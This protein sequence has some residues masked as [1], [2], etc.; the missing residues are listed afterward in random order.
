MVPDNNVDTTSRQSVWS[1]VSGGTTTF[2]VKAV[3]TAGTWGATATFSLR[4]DTNAPVTTCDTDAS[5]HTNSFV[6]RLSATDDQSGV[7]KTQYRVNNGSVQIGTNVQISTEGSNTLAFWSSDSAGNIEAT[8]QVAGIK[9]DLGG[10]VFANWMLSP[11]N[12]TSASTGSARISVEVNDAVSGIGTNIPMIDYYMT[13][14]AYG[15]WKAMGKAGNAWTFDVATNWISQGNKSL[16]WKV[17]ARDVAGHVVASPEQSEY[18]DRTAD[19]SASK[20]VNQSKPNV[21]E[22]ITYTLRLTNSGPDAATGIEVT[23][24]LPSGLTY[25]SHAGGAYNS[26]AGLWT[27]GTLASGSSTTMTIQATVNTGTAG[28][29]VINTAR[30]SAVQQADTNAGNNVATASL[31][32][33]GAD[34]GVS[35]VVNNSTPNQGD[36]VAFTVTARNFGPDSANNV[37]VTDLIPTGL[38][39]KGTNAS[40]G[41]YS[42]ATGLWQV[43]ILTNGGSATLQLSAQVNDGTAGSTI[44]NWATKTFSTEADGNTAND[45]AMASVRVLMADI[46]V[47][48]TVSGTEPSEGSMIAYTLVATNS[49]PDGAT[50][51]QVLDMLPSGLTYSSHSGGTYVSSSGIWTIGALASSGSTSLVIQARVN[52]GTGGSSITNTAQV[53]TC[54]QTDSNP[55]NNTGKVSI[56]VQAADLAITKVVN[57]SQPNVGDSIIYTVAVT[58]KGPNG[59]T[60]VTVNDMLPAGIIYGGAVPSQGSYN[61]RIWNVGSLAIHGS[62]NLQILATIAA[63]TAGMTITN[64][65]F[66]LANQSDPTMAD[67]TN[68]VVLRVQ[69]ADL[70]IFKSVNQSKPNVGETITYT[71]RLTNSGPDAA[72]GIEVTDRLPSGLTYSSHAGGAYN[73][74]AGLWTVGTLASG[75]STT[76]T[77]QAT[78]NTGT[79]GSTV[80]NTARVSAVQQADTNA[81]NNV[82]TASLQVRGA[83]V[84]VS[85]VVNNSTPNQGDM[86]A[87]TVTARNF[88]PD[89]ANNVQVTDLIPTGLTIK[90]TNA[91]QGSY[92]GATG[93]WQVGILTNGGSATLQLSAQ[94]NDGTAGST[95]T[96]WATK[97]FSTEADGNTA[98]D[99]AGVTITVVSADLA[100]SKTATPIT[101]LPGSNVMYTISVTNIGPY[102][103]HN[104]VVTDTLP[105]QADLIEV[106][107]SVGDWSTN[108]SSVVFHLGSLSPQTHATMTV[109]L[110]ASQETV[111]TNMASVTATEPDTIPANN[112]ASVE[113]IASSNL[114]VM[115]TGQAFLVDTN[116]VISYQANPAVDM[117]AEGNFV[118]VWETLRGYDPAD[119]QVVGQR[120]DASG[121]AQGDQFVAASKTLPHITPQ[122]HWNP[123]QRWYPYYPDVSLDRNGNS[124]IV[125]FS[126]DLG[127][128]FRR[129]S[130]TGLPLGPEVGTGFST[131]ALYPYGFPG[132]QVVLGSL[133]RFFISMSRYSHLG[134]SGLLNLYDFNNATSGPVKTTAYNNSAAPSLIGVDAANSFCVMNDGNWQIVDSNGNFIGSPMP[135]GT[136]GTPVGLAMATNGDFVVALQYW[137]HSEWSIYAQRYSQMAEPKGAAILVHQYPLPLAAY[138]EEIVVDCADD[139][140]F[141]VV[142]SEW[143]SENG[144]GYA[145]LCMRRFDASGNPME[146]TQKVTGGNYAFAPRIAMN[147]TGDCVVVWQNYKTPRG[148]AWEQ[149]DIFAKRYGRLSSGS[150][151]LGIQAGSSTLYPNAGDAV[152]FEVVISN[153]SAATAAAVVVKCALS[154]NI[155]V[156]SWDPTDGFDPATETWSIGSLSPGSSA[157]LS[158]NGIVNIGA[159]GLSLSNAWTIQAGTVNDDQLNNN[160]CFVVQTVRTGTPKML[161]VS[162]GQNVTISPSGGVAVAEG[163]T[164]T[165][166]ITAAPD[167]HI[168]QMLING[169]RMRMRAD[170]M[171]TNIAFDNIRSDATLYVSARRHH[172]PSS[173]LSLYALASD[174]YIGWED[175]DNDGMANWQEYYA[176]TDPLD[177]L[178]Y[179]MITDMSQAVGRTLVEWSTSRFRPDFPFVVQS[180][181]GANLA[182]WTTD[183]REVRSTAPAALQWTEDVQPQSQRAG[184]YRLMVD[185]DWGG[186]CPTFIQ[187]SRDSPERPTPLRMDATSSNLVA[188]IM[189]PVENALLRSDIPIYGVAGG[190]NF[191]DYRV[192]YGEGY[193]PEQWHLIEASSNSQNMSPDFG[194]ISWMQGDLDLRGNLATWNTGL[195]NWEHLPWHPADDPTDF[196]GV[197][198]IRLVSQGRTGDLLEDRVTCEVGRA[199]A[200]CLPGIA[201]SP[202]KTVVMRFPEQALSDKFR[203]YTIF[204]FTMLG[205]AVPL[206]Q[207]DM[208]LLTDAYRIREPGEMFIKDVSLEFSWKDDGSTPASNIGIC[209]YDSTSGK[210]I[211]MQTRWDDSCK[212][213]STTIQELPSPEAIYALASDKSTARS[214]QIGQPAPTDPLKPV[215]RGVLLENDFE[216]GLG[217][218]RARDRNVGAQISIV[219]RDSGG[220]CLEAVNPVEKGNYSFTVLNSP[221]DVSEYPHL[222]FE[223]KID[224]EAKVDLFLRV[225]GRWYR[226]RLTGDNIDFYGKDVNIADLGKVTECTADDEWHSCGIDLRA[227]LRK[228]T[229]HSIVEEMIFANWS[230]AGYM[231]LDFGQNV[232]GARIQLDN[233]RIKSS[234]T[235]DS[236]G[237][238]VLWIDR[239]S[240]AASRNELGNLVGS[241]GPENNECRATRMPL[242]G[243]DGNCLVLDIDVSPPGSF[244][245]Y[246]TELG[247]RNLTEYGSICFRVCST[248]ELM[249]EIAL[250][251]V[252]GR[253]VIVPSL[254]CVKRSGPSGWTDVQILL[255]PLGSAIDLVHVAV[256]SFGFS[257]ASAADV[258]RV[259]LDDIRFEPSPI[260]S[261]KPIPVADYEGRDMQWNLLGGRNFTFENGAG[262]IHASQVRRR[263]NG[264]IGG[265]C[266]LLAYGG[267]IGLDLGQDGFS[268][269][270]WEA[271]LGGIDLSSHRYLEMSI[272]GLQGG[273]QPNVYLTDG[274]MKRGVDLEKYGQVGTEWSVIRIPIRDFADRGID[275]THVESLEFVFEWD[276]MSGAICLDDVSFQ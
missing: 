129:Y 93:L 26:G 110:M 49:G 16:F 20:T 90:G 4:V 242:D 58:N 112:S 214:E 119:Y 233:M 120:F 125:W 47:A 66:V 268:F 7:A 231:A 152:S 61:G 253:Q 95:I 247:D 246:W 151:N 19:L 84:G 248:N 106:N 234:V 138:P 46:G 143:G 276:R 181:P 263:E 161:T 38:T 261:G 54:N 82:A 94:V 117:D 3:N 55:A 171:S 254:D 258:G 185:N 35:K 165:I 199:I 256:L 87:F 102:T 154:Q 195:K 81:G 74:G 203:V 265:Q 169:V 215:Q 225:S 30:V 131:N 97:T 157:T 140:S 41:S 136:T 115:V 170:V 103:A 212:T 217:T 1:N 158:L 238:E 260:V 59:A 167:Y 274:V 183:E 223:Y 25:S 216:Q 173:W 240:G 163:G 83:D 176:G 147:A 99:Q 272:R 201:I 96:N 36:M 67:R 132:P 121:R 235:L 150:V 198:T 45:Q 213:F 68:R 266:L 126:E 230:V 241:F 264:K 184:F 250:K 172:L 177:P 164:A 6:A 21:G 273:E 86:V 186:I 122:T 134:Y 228:K 31:Q 243:T 124:V 17:Q 155:S 255:P 64:E 204:P 166:N 141:A 37:Q 133:G 78:V 18:I 236:T 107:S 190:T 85:K 209:R 178:S 182:A 175:T 69:A 153:G 62:A 60:G 130:A 208:R 52:A 71:L 229:G 14:G 65:A 205:R 104:V 12:L 92:S 206:V 219:A 15:G 160:R 29:T 100:I 244:G 39:I 91:S 48:K 207:P 123:Y 72:T 249:P 8:S 98:N 251:D 200:Q 42:G 168:D 116:P 239:F 9:L 149:G 75:S 10:P 28:S 57:N 179:L 24:R 142:W 139:G 70:G 211:W 23:D 144:Y 218:L 114:N 259:L 148:E 11:T 192:E 252:G 77:I 32:V 108:S 101:V 188:R 128:Q 275:I 191:A 194:D 135:V 111:L 267:S 269:C 189:I 187:L 271:K 5:W 105:S 109:T 237:P 224:R 40:Q 51:L 196:N 56:V 88:G 50:G 76:M 232:P 210:W 162:C 79:A 43:G 33:R 80:I 202:D 159:A 257:S 137:S 2:Y 127:V 27:V 145:D 89:S 34:V 73:S 13:G 197:Y 262:S 227:A 220:H 44:T 146:L 270:G 22:T 245:G 156:T 63:G 118:V 180:S 53:Y 193:N 221:F 226:I 174:Y 113:V 222:S